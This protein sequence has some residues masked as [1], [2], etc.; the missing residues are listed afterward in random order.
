MINPAQVLPTNGRVYS[1]P[2]ETIFSRLEPLYSRI[3]S[4]FTTAI[5]II[6]SYYENV[7]YAWKNSISF[8]ILPS[9]ALSFLDVPVFYEQVPFA[10]TTLMAAHPGRRHISYEEKRLQ[11]AIGVTLDGVEIS[12]RT[13]RGEKS[14]RTI[15]YFLPNGKIWPLHLEKL[16]FLS[17]S[18]RANVVCYNYRGTGRSGGVAL[19]EDDLVSDSIKI[20]E[21]ELP[22]GLP[23]IHSY[24]L[25]GGVAMQVLKYFEDRNISLSSCNERSFQSIAKIIKAWHWLY[26]PIGWIASATGWTLNSEAVLP[27]LRG[28]HIFMSHP[29]DEVIIGGARLREAATPLHRPNFHFIDMA[30]NGGHNTRW[31]ASDSANYIPLVEHYFSS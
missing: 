23:F 25:G 19:S 4:I 30:P 27:S 24:S 1:L 31:D 7:S 15:V 16:L 28:T 5:S 20:V 17:S 3:Q 8:I 9:R 11:V 13:S 21:H 6:K 2:E 29:N 10:F 18:L 12:Y 26:S 22:H 14:T